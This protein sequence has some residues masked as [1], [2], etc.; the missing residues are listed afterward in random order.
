V[1]AK[2]VIENLKNKPMRSLLSFLLIGVPVT[3]ILT[4]QGLTSGMLNDAKERA[5]GV[6]ADILVRASST[7]TG[8]YQSADSVPEKFVGYFR[9]EVPHVK[10]AIGVINHS[11]EFPLIITGLNQDEFNAM[12]GGFQ[13]VAGHPLREPD[14]ILVDRLYAKQK[15]LQPGAD[16][17]LLNHNWHLVGIIEGGKLARV[18]VSLGRLQEV[19]G[20]PDKVTS[21]YVKLDDPANIDAVVDFIDQNSGSVKAQPMADYTE[22]TYNV[23]NYPGLSEFMYVVMAI[24]VVIGFG[25]VCLSM[26]MA[27]LQRT[28]EIGILKAIGASNI[29]ILRIILAEAMVLAIGGT[30]FGIL[31]SFVAWWLIRTLVPSSLAIEIV[32]LWW[33]IAGAITLL[34]AALGALYPGWNAARHDA[35]EAL[36]YE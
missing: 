24:G 35:I 4:L 21:I 13:F 32:P 1:T 30:I 15:R 22:A 18:V 5:R 28:R 14:D 2:L 31:L 34:G 8:V 7:Q 33:P 27:V 16:I 6:G 11:I 25:V 19:L 26:Y 29:F 20:T 17:K 36:A 23:A 10:Q 12:S 9:G 3:L